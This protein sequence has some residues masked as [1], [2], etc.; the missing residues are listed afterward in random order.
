[1]EKDLLYRLALIRVPGIGPIHAKALFNYFGEA[2]AIFRASR[3]FLEKIRGI[4]QQR[5]ASIIAFRDFHAAE[6]ELA[7]LERWSIRPLF[8]TD[9]SYPVRLL[10]CPQAPA[11]LFYKGNAD[12]NA[13]KILSVVGTRTPSEYGR[14]VVEK[15]ISELDIPGLLVVSGLAYGI[16]AAAHK[17]ALKHH[18]PTIG[19]LAH[20][21]DKVYPQ[22]HAGMAKEMIRQGGLLTEFCSRTE[23]DEF[24]FPVRNR[25][26]A[27]MSDALLVVE[28]GCRGGS[29]LTV[30]NARTCGRKIFAIPGRI[31]DD[32]SAGCNL[33]I[34]EG[35]ALLLSSARQF[36][37]DMQWEQEQPISKKSN[38]QAVIFPQKSGSGGVA[39]LSDPAMVPEPS[40]EEK[41]LPEDEKTVLYLLRQRGRLIYDEIRLRTAISAAI[42]PLILLNLELQGWIRALPGRTYISSS[43]ASA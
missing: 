19:V 18:L 12:L 9:K 39:A 41:A 16:D 1:M 11:L 26:V 40:E 3:A 34:R 31:T 6:E 32:R 20:G 37:Q 43:P 15:F 10:T 28:T 5:A 24:N 27:G 21:L 42:L 36:I 35:K 8:F 23:P 7:F 29:M 17:S 4:G 22:Q 13:P 2:E 14:R 30:E 33:L 25:I 38:Q